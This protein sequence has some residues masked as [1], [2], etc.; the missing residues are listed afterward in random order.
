MRRYRTRTQRVADGLRQEILTGALV[1]GQELAFDHLAARY[2]VS[3]IPVREALRN[4]GAEGLVELR[5][6]RAPRVRPY[7][8]DEVQELWWIRELLEPEVARLAVRGATPSLVRSLTRLLGRMEGMGPRPDTVRWLAVNRTFHLA[9]Y[10]A[11]GRLQ[12]LRLVTDLFDQSVRYVGVFLRSPE[13]FRTTNG[14]HVEILAAFAA[15]DGSR[16]AHL[17]RTHIEG[18]RLWLTERFG[19]GV[20]R[21]TP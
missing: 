9:M 2:G 18:V 20:Q 11:A 19:D 14:Q 12:L 8:P 16:L 7:S 17:T 15:R 6:H 3:R 13:Q 10:A 5:P 4:L 21:S 1:P